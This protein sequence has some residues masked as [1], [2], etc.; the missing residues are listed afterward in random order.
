MGKGSAAITLTTSDGLR[1]GG[2]VGLQRAFETSA[3]GL[4]AAAKY[5]DGWL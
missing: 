2:C 1:K 3:S 4:S 5:G